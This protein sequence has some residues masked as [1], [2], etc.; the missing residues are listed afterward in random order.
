MERATLSIEGM[1]CGHCVQAVTRALQEVEGVRVEHVGVGIAEVSFDP[2]AATPE[3]IA[4][5]VQDEGYEVV[6]TRRAS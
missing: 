1:S 6:S 3:R 5:A 2:A 4:T